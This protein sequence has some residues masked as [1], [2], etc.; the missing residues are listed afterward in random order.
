MSHKA[1][2]I[3]FTLVRNRHIQ[4]RKEQLESLV[5]A[6]VSDRFANESAAEI[7]RAVAGQ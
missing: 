2:C 4:I 5:N 3:E 1:G 7:I 6:L